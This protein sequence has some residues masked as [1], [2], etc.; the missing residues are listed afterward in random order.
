[1]V[2]LMV[3]NSIKVFPAQ[4]DQPSFLRNHITTFA[5]LYIQCIHSYLLVHVRTA[6]NGYFELIETVNVTVY[7]LSV[8]V[9]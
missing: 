7:L 3:V 8:S 2:D 6:M 4:L 9:K 5:F 1:M